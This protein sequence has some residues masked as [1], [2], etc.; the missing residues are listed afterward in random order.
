MYDKLSVNDYFKIIKKNQKD[1]IDSHTSTHLQDYAVAGKKAVLEDYLT[2]LESYRKTE[3]FFL[4][5][6]IKS[7]SIASKIERGTLSVLLGIGAGA[8][9]FAAQQRFPSA[10]VFGAKTLTQGGFSVV[11]GAIV[12]SVIGAA[13]EKSQQK[14]LNL[15]YEDLQ[16]DMQDAG[17]SAQKFSQ[18]E[19]DLVKL[20][21][22]RECI[23]LDLNDGGKVPMRQTF[24]TRY[25]HEN[26]AVKFDDSD[27][28]EA[29]E[30]YFLQQ[31]DMLFHQ[32][33][34]DIYQLHQKEI[35]KERNS[36]VHWFKKQFASK[37]NQQQVTQQIQIQFI[38][39][40]MHYLEKE[41]SQ[42]GFLGE[43]SLIIACSAGLVLGAITLALFAITNILLPLIALI[44]IGV[45]MAS[46]V[47]I[48]TYSLITRNESLFYKRAPRN[49]EAIQHAILSI[50]KEQKRLNTLI[51]H[52]VPTSSQEI[53]ALN[54][55]NAINDLTLQVF[56]GAETKKHIAF[57][58]ARAWI[59]EFASRYRDNKII[60]IELGTGI[61]ELVEDAYKQT[62][63]LQ[64][65]LMQWSKAKRTSLKAWNKC[66][67]DTEAYLQAPKSAEFIK[68]FNVIQKIKEQLLECVGH[69]P[70]TYHAELPAS[71]VNFYTNTLG[72]LN[73]DLTQAIRLTP[74]V[75]NST[76]LES[77][78]YTLLL[79]IAFRLNN[80]LTALPDNNLV[81]KGE[82]TYRQL[83]GLRATPTLVADHPLTLER[84]DSL[85]TASFDF[86]CSL[87]NYSLSTDWDKP[88]QHSDDYILYRML[89]VKQLAVWVDPNNLQVDPFIKTK[90]IQFA[91]DKLHYNACNSFSDI[92]SQTFL[93]G[94]YN[95]S[96]TINDPLGN[97]HCLA[98][99]N[100]IADALRV[101]IAHDLNP[102][103]AQRLIN[104]HAEKFLTAN[105][106]HML[107]G[108]HPH[109]LIIEASP[110]SEQEIIAAIN[111]TTLFM[112]TI[113]NDALLTSTRSLTLYQQEVG[114][115][116]EQLIRASQTIAQARNSQLITHILQLL[117][118]FKLTLPTTVVPEQTAVPDAATAQLITQL[119]TF[120]NR[121][122]NQRLNFFQQHNKADKKDAAEAIINTLKA[123]QPVPAAYL[124]AH[125]IYQK[126]KHLKAIIT[127]IQKNHN[128]PAA[129][130]GI[131]SQ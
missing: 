63:Q 124:A 28:T 116:V 81:C 35:A 45:A 122:D 36:L 17:F 67:R 2:N 65:E 76:Q 121:Q 64:Q 34:E 113:S 49:R 94:C 107:L 80:Q 56:F 72:G 30:V 43:Y 85:L 109:K 111:S 127:K 70:H 23:L 55:F 120:K 97:T 8:S 31:L 42:P 62:N 25:Y 115:E 29:I 20:F 90:I 44:S 73:S 106:Q 12:A 40:C 4:S 58:S 61:E 83:L 6:E 102:L 129:V 123:K 59:R 14:P 103:S 1:Y 37:E 128:A 101:D 84:L 104:L 32:S 11:M 126:N 105:T 86:L 110:E 125:S 69:L 68:K 60:E 131:N 51:Q 47:S 78:P 93:Q 96:R 48:S 112:Q 19:A 54:N 9:L 77:H 27:L 39:A 26:S 82:N 114:K 57:G 22:F 7:P 13:W 117:T 99:L 5:D 18:L 10:D 38:T 3:D 21:H 46:V 95:D 118:T 33:L 119:V 15:D 24:K 108:L 66:I 53:D 87:N 91:Q 52:V 89:F 98:G 130:V 16:K 79:D 71:L 50:S 92:T 41:M 88:F 74:L 100:V 75:T